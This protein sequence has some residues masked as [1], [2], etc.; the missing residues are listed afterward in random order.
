MIR[1]PSGVKVGWTADPPPAATSVTCRMPDPSGATTQMSLR[2]PPGSPPSPGA[3]K[4]ISVP[5]G[6]QSG[7]FAYR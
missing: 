3:E 6:L 1:P 2:A 4:A 5:S 7:L